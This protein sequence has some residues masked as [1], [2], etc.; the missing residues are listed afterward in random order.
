L[1]LRRATGFPAGKSAS[2][3]RTE[4][5]AD[6][7][8]PSSAD[9][10]LHTLLWHDAKLSIVITLLAKLSTLA[11]RKILHILSHMRVWAARGSAVVF[12]KIAP[13]LFYSRRFS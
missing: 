6:D 8:P 4:R 5:E 7:S 1:L 3:K 9:V 10:T 2:A 12:L 13:K 11:I